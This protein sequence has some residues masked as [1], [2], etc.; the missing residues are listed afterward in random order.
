MPNN[1]KIFKIEPLPKG[2][3]NS[4][5]YL[6]KALKEIRTNP[7]NHGYPKDEVIRILA[8]E[9]DISESTSEHIKS[10]KPLLSLVKDFN[11]AFIEF[12]KGHVAVINKLHE[13]SKMGWFVSPDIIRDIEYDKFLHLVYSKESSRIDDQILANFAQTNKVNKILRSVGK[14]FPNRSQILD[15]VSKAYEIGLYSSVINVCYSQADGICNEVWNFGFFDKDRSKDYALK[16]HTNLSQYDY[17]SSNSFVSQLGFSENE[18]T[19]N[20]EDKIFKNKK[21]QLITFNRHHVLHGH[22]TNY[23][24]QTNALR[25]ILLLDF[26]NHFVRVYRKKNCD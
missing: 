7:K 22:A 10:I 3:P 15:E 1:N 12:K 23:G 2:H 4:M 6:I 8:I 21:R 14:E 18:I 9:N 25:S 13:L 17:G 11:E 20:S 26:I 16:L 19:I 5:G 24:N